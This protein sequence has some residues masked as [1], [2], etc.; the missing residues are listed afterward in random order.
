MVGSEQ[1]LTLFYGKDKTDYTL[2][3]IL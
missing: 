3:K 1:F 2:K